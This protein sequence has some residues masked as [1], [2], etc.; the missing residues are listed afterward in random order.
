[1]L[2]V[3]FLGVLS[4]SSEEQRG[5]S[6]NLCQSLR[7]NDRRHMGC[8]LVIDFCLLSYEFAPL[9]GHF[10]RKYN[11]VETCNCYDRAD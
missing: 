8:V 10:N 2:S 3:A 7:E 1:M 5:L 4:S 9:S 6:V 11:F